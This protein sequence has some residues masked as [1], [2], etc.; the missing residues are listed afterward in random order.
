MLSIENT[1]LISAIWV[2]DLVGGLVDQER[3]AG[4]EDQVL[5]RDA[6]AKHEEPGFGEPDDPADEQEQDQARHQS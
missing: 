3:A 4:G 1:R 5:A 2:M 6:V